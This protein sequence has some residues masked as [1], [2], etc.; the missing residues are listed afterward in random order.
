MRAAVFA[1]LGLAACQPDFAAPLSLV[2][3]PRLLAVRAEPPEAATGDVVTLTPLV[4]APDGTVL[5]PALRWSLCLEPKATSENGAVS[6]A[7]LADGG[8]TALAGP[9]LRL[10]A[11]GCRLFGPDVPPPLAGQPPT[12]PRAPDATG[13]YYQPLRADLDGAPSGIVLERLRCA[14]AGASLELARAFQQQYTPNQ[15]PQLTPLIT[16]RDGRTITLS[17]GW[18]ASSAESY[19]VIDTLSQTLVL[20]RE[21]LT[22]SW[23]VSAGT[24]RDGRTGR[25]ADDAALETSNRWT[26]PA[27]A[28]TVHLWLVLRDSRGGVDFASYELD[29]DGA[30]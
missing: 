10:P 29:A 17:A 25:S 8:T 4:A 5:M 14:P 30:R 23:Y 1:V 22:V 15:N 18:T 16:T 19:P 6:P 24:L 21:A 2:D 20:Q 28:G 3:G 7:C 13:G 26:A 12:A 11:D 27:D 9:T